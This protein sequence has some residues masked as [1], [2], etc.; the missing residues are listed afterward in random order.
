MSTALFAQERVELLYASKTFQI[1]HIVEDHF[2]MVH[3]EGDMDIMS[4][5]YLF[6][7][8]EYTQ[9]NYLSMN[10]NGGY[11]NEAYILGNF[12]KTTPDI[13]F[14]VR[15]DNI[16][17][18]ACAFAALSAKKL[19]IGQNGLDFHSPYIPYVDS[20]ATLHEF[21]KESQKSML[22]LMKYLDEVG[23][24]YDFLS[25][26]LEYTS[27]S[28]FVTFYTVNDL[29]YYKVENFFDRIARI[30]PGVKY[31]LNTR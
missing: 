9:T 20:F 19:M 4:S 27:P 21:S 3:F 5:F 30:D 29:E 22:M 23:Y 8:L 24:G 2:D 11:M 16:C 6:T 13:T 26:M 7:A 12:L 1:Y 15:N 28:D 17:V 10:S 14:V 31:K 25:L 18:S